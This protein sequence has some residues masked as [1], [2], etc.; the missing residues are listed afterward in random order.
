MIKVCSLYVPHP[1]DAAA[2]Y[3]AAM[4]KVFNSIGQYKG[5]GDLLAWIR[6][7]VVNTCIDHCRRE[8]RFVV[9][10]LVYTAEEEF[11]THPE[12]YDRLSAADAIQLLQ[13]LPPASGMVFKLFVLEG[14]KH[15]EIAGQLNISTGT[16]KWH[17]NEA[18]RLLQQKLA[19]IANNTFISNAG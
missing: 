4:L 15:S 19:A 7:I 13:G 5:S 18:R 6:R 1:E 2:L 14:Y 17:L 11:A 8:A 3:N 16:S 10:P 9:Q 12:V